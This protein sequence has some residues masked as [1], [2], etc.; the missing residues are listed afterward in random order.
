MSAW[1]IDPDG[2]R[3]VLS[4]TETARGDLASTVSPLPDAIDDLYAVCP[5][6]VSSVPAALQSILDQQLG[7]LS[8]VLTR[9]DAAVFGAARAAGYY[10]LADTEMAANIQAAAITAAT[11]GDVS[12]LQAYADG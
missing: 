2:V 7:E 9:V 5:G 1:S 12:A 6:F 8:V 3:A 10:L 4:S 11:S